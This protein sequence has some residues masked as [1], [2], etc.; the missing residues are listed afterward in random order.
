MIGL[1]SQFLARKLVTKVTQVKV[2]CHMSTVESKALCC[3]L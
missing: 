2:A 3:R 1:V